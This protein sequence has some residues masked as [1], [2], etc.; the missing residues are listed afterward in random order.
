MSIYKTCHAILKGAGAVARHRVGSQS[1]FSSS[2]MADDFICILRD[3]FKRFIEELPY[4]ELRQSISTE[5]LEVADR[6][7][8]LLERICR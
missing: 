8:A 4:E 5:E 7:L 2:I 1:L 6:L 3:E